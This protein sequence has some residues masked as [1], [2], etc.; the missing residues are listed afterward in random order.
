MLLSHLVFGKNIQEAVDVLRWRHYSGLRVGLEQGTP[1]ETL[2]ALVRMGHQ[3]SLSGG[4]SFGGAQVILV[5]PKTGTY[6]G[7]SDPRKDG[8]AVGY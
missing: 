8:A 5:D 1:L 4:G 7:A 2:S 3:I 6:F